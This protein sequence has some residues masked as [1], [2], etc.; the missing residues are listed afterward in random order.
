MRQGFENIGVVFEAAGERQGANL[1]RTHH[2]I[3]APV[4][5]KLIRSRPPGNAGAGLTTLACPPRATAEC[6]PREGHSRRDRQT[7]VALGEVDPSTAPHAATRSDRRA[8][9][10]RS[11]PGIE[12]WTRWVSSWPLLYFSPFWC[13]LSL[14]YVS[15][16]DSG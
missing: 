2:F 16:R 6:Q 10:A 14:G 13:L 12:I 11:G 7:A 8:T 4:G 9:P 5:R 15:V 3:T 1:L